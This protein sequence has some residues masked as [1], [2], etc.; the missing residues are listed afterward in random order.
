MGI[1]GN[2]SN[3]GCPIVSSI[4]QVKEQKRAIIFRYSE[5]DN[6]KALRQVLATLVPLALLWWIAVLSIDVSRW[7]TALLILPISLFA[8]RVFVLMHEC[9]HGSLFRMRW[10]NRAC[11]FC[12][13][14]IAGMPQYVWS[15]HHNYHHAHN[16]DWDLYRGLYTTLSVDEYAAMTGA[17][18]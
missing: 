11:G 13:G 4:H 12:L 8:L 7:I 16:G 2:N 6:A 1:L 3:P 15:R 10:L 9:G 5:A 17:Q 18:Q 14:V